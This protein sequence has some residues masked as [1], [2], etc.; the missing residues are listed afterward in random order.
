MGAGDLVILE[1][2]KWDWFVSCTVKKRNAS[3]VY[4]NKKSFALLRWIARKNKVPFHRLPFAMR[5][6][7]GVSPEHRHF[8]LLVDGLVHTGISMRMAVIARW[9]YSLGGKEPENPRGT[10]RVRLYDGRR[11]A[12]HYLASQLNSAEYQGWA[13]LYVRISHAALSLARYGAC[14]SAAGIG[15][16]HRS[17]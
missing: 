16:F 11:G 3:D 8:H 2:V 1:R 7:S 12:A 17:M 10:C 6:E 15:A 13:N 14:S 5:L 9:N 4:L